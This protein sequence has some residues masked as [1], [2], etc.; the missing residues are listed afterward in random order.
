LAIWAQLTVPAEKRQCYGRMVGDSNMSADA[1]TQR[2]FGKIAGPTYSD[3]ASYTTSATVG[4]VCCGAVGYLPGCTLY[5]PLQFWFNRVPGLALP[6]VGL[7]FHQVRLTFVFESISKLCGCSVKNTSGAALVTTTVPAIKI[8]G[9]ALISSS[10]D[11][12]GINPENSVERIALT[13]SQ[14]TG[15]KIQLFATQYN[16]G[17]PERTAIAG[18]AREYLIEQVQSSGAESILGTSQSIRIQLSHPVKFL[19]WTARPTTNGSEAAADTHDFQSYPH[20]TDLHMDAVSAHAKHNS[21]LSEHAYFSTGTKNQLAKSS[22]S[23]CGFN[24]L[25]SVGLKF[26]SSERFVPR[27]GTYFNLVQPYEHFP[28]CPTDAGIMVYSFALRPCEQQPTG[29]ANFSRLD[30]VNMIVA[31]RFTGG[32]ASG[33]KAKVDQLV[34]SKANL[35]FVYYAVNLNTFVVSSGLGGLLWAN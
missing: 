28:S 31:P 13:D 27:D 16:L 33:T 17:R 6:L 32:S 2:L 18:N 35:E 21:C 3:F 26:N 4:T 30:Q 12:L 24:P 7:Q 15:T 8:N 34:A 9:G 14:I 19:A 23:K 22:T 5:V 29:S 11:S 25:V 10:S 20:G 1:L